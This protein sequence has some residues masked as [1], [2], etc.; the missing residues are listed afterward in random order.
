MNTASRD[1]L[2]TPSG[3]RARWVPLSH[4]VRISAAVCATVATSLILGAQLGIVALYSGELG[5]ALAAIKVQPRAVP[6]LASASSS[7]PARDGMPA[8]GVAQ[9]AP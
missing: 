5:T 7:L 8:L 6:A 3:T 4:T 9:L 1:V 2:D